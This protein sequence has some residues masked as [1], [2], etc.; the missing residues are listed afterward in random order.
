MTAFDF[1]T[2][3]NRLAQHSVKWHDSEHDPELLQLWV[4]DMDFVPFAG[5]RNALMQYAAEH[6]YG[7]SYPS[8]AYYQAII[9]WEQHEHQYTVQKEQLVLLPAVV[10]AISVAI[11]AFSQPGDAV[12]INTPVYPPFAR[13]IR[14]NN[15]QLINHSLEIRNGR[16]ELDFDRLANDFA[17]H[18]VRIYLLCN[19]HNPGGRIW[20][21]DELRRIVQLCAQHDVLLISDEI[22]QDLALYGH[23]HCTINS[24]NHD[25]I[26]RTIMLSSASKTFNIAGLKNSFAIIEDAQVRTAF[27]QQQLANN[28]AELPTVGLIATQVAYET[29]KPWL[30]ALKSVLET[31]IDYVCDALSQHTDIRVMKPEGT[32]LIWL[33]FAAYGLQQPQLHR[34]LKN[35]AKVV[36][37]DG[38]AFGTE[39]RTFARLNA[40]APLPV[41][42][43]ACRRIIRTFPKK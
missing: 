9:D 37:N 17:T 40:A 20:S 8:D 28:Q 42:E 22:H 38:A 33:D 14:A 18:K 16:F 32:Y 4:A 34:T 29:G 41:I 39:G 1:T 21:A 36:L 26:A 13:T 6:V 43:E 30:H 35:T 2:K 3:P 31:N 15:R 19:P 27:K 12:L 11:Q 7:Y 10:P 5:I 25:R 23:R 24:V